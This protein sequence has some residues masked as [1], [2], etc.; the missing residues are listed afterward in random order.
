MEIPARLL[1]MVITALV[2]SGMRAQAQ[3]LAEFCASPYKAVCEHQQ[4][5]KT[6]EARIEKIEK[7]LTDRALDEA[8]E[9]LYGSKNRPDSF[10]VDDIMYMPGKMERKRAQRVFYASLRKQFREYLKQNRVPTDLN[11]SEIKAHLSQAIELSREIP[12]E[13][14]AQMQHLLQ[15]IRLIA[16]NDLDPEE[17]GALTVREI[18]LIYKGC[19]KHH[20]V[21]NAFADSNKKG[22]KFVIIC[23]GEIV[24]TIEFAKDYGIP[25]EYQLVPLIMTLGHELSHHF[26]F[27]VM[28]E[29]YTS[30]LKTV[31]DL[32]SELKHSKVENYMGEV[33]ADIWGVK[34]FV[35]ATYNMTPELQMTF[36]KGAVNDLC[37]TEDD[38][39]HPSGQFRINRLLPPYLCRAR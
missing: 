4:N 27:S 35:L 19:T 37:G 29:A 8:F 22:E 1:L 21:D 12:A 16:F 36:V 10:T 33:T 20:F 38:G 14:K 13:N 2:V 31:T 32:K 7:R 39:V 3:T 18:N 9:Y 30:A 5:A 24:G 17:E 25:R 15:E 34:T 26:D 23:P 6:R 11:I 28:P